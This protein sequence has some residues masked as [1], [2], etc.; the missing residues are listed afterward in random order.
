M[1]SLCQSLLHT[2]LVFIHANMSTTVAS[3]SNA[4]RLVV[5]SF[6]LAP[7]HEGSETKRLRPGGSRSSSGPEPGAP[8]GPPRC[9]ATPLQRLEVAA[10]VS[11]NSAAGAAGAAGI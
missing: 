1:P 4:N 5:F 3:P 8:S 2:K 10:G 9:P 6:L 7:H 11:G